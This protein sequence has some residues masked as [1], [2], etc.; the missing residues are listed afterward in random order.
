MLP[1]LQTK[2]TLH[3]APDYINKSIYETN[4]PEGSLVINEDRTVLGR[5]GRYSYRPTASSSGAVELVLPEGRSVRFHAV[6]K[7]IVDGAVVV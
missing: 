5:I 7:Y 4:A 3:Q 2:Q 1:L 6:V